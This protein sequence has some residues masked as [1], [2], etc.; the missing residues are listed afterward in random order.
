M[1]LF[2]YFSMCMIIIIIII[3]I[4]LIIIYQFSSFCFPEGRFPGGRPRLLRPGG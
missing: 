4:I 3:I 1:Y 2:I